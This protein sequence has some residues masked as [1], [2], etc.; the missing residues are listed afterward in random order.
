MGISIGHLYFYLVEVYPAAHGGRSMIRTPAF[1]SAIVEI[2]TGLSP[3]IA[4]TPG[5]RGRVKALPSQ[6]GRPNEPT[7]VDLPSANNVNSNSSNMR[8]RGAVKNRP[9]SY[10]WGRGRTLGAN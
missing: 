10:N 4:P 7:P 8:H 9:G 2:L 5:T 3:W 1:C 6:V